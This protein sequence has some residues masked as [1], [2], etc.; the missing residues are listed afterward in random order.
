MGAIVGGLIAA[1]VFSGFLWSGIIFVYN[2][3]YFSGSR[4]EK[5]QYHIL[6]RI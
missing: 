2:C 3:G 6:S 5:E 1:A 4:I